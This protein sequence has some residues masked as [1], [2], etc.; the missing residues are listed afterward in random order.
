MPALC[1]WGISVRVGFNEIVCTHP[2]E[3]LYSMYT[4][5]A[6]TQPGWQKGD[7]GMSYMYSAIYHVYIHL[8]ALSDNIALRSNFWEISCFCVAFLN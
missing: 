3:Y 7:F 8:S 1:D 4:Q 6:N 2:E 5:F